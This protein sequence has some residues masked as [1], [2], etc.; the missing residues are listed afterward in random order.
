ML[1]EKTL[2]LLALLIAH[3][4]G[5]ALVVP[6]V[7]RPSTLAPPYPSAADAAEKKRKMGKQIDKKSSE[8]GEIAQSTQQPPLPPKE[9]RVMRTQQKKGTSARAGKSAEGE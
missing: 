3:T 8:E 1:E 7:P 5:T 2:D 6:V 9:S 4:G